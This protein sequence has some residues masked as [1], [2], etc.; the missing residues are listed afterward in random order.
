MHAYAPVP[1]CAPTRQSLLSGEWPQAHGGL[2]NYGVGLPL[3]LFDRPTWSEALAG[4]GYRL[5]YVGKWGVHPNR[6]PLAFGFH[7]WVSS[8]DYAAW[9]SA[10]SLPAPVSSAESIKELRDSPA[11]RWF[12]GS[13]PV[14]AGCSRTHWCADATIDL[15]ERYTHTGRTNDEARPWC[16]QLALEEP[17]L[18]PYPAGEFAEMYPPETIPP[19]GS[20]GD[21]LNG[22][23]YIQRQQR[24][25]WGIEELGWGAWS[26]FVVYED[27]DNL[28]L[29]RIYYYQG[30]EA[31]P[32]MDRR[33]R[34]RGFLAPADPTVT[35]TYLV[36]EGDAPIQGDSLR[37]NGVDVQ[38]GCNPNRNVF[39][40][41]I[42]SGRADGS[43]LEGVDGVDLDTFTVEGAIDAGD[44]E[45]EI[46][47]VVPRG[48]GLVTP[49][50]VI[51]TDWLVLAFDHR[52]PSF[53]SVKPQ[54]EAQ[55][56]TGSSVEP[57]QRIDYV[58][59]IENTGGDLANDV[60]VQDGIPEHTTYI[61]GSARV[62][63]QAVAD[64]GD[65]SPFEDGFDVSGFGGIG[66]FEPGERHVVAFSVQVDEG[67]PRGAE[68]RNV[69][70][71]R[72]REL[73]ADEE[74]DPV[75]HLVG[76]ATDMRPPPPPRDMDPPD[77]DMA[78]AGVDVGA[79]PDAT[80]G[81][82]LDAGRCPPG[83]RVDIRGDCED[84]P[85]PDAGPM[86]MDDPVCGPGAQR[87][88]GQ[89]ALI[90]GEGL[91]WDTN[92]D[93]C[94]RC[95]IATDMPCPER[96]APGDAEDKGGSD[97]GCGCDGT[98]VGGIWLLM[99]PGLRRRRR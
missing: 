90:C 67:A 52:L 82:D 76:D 31:L 89:C 57:G 77:P 20:L 12:G 22:K 10:R 29:R 99:L 14:P 5:G 98:G 73:E 37:V 59:I 66:A 64:I 50:E 23:P 51:F 53:E 16:I 71:I 80:G 18:P 17:H 62:G 43:C 49:G 88:D 28:P 84:A 6:S 9:R 40:G 81:G 39:N 92:C 32:G 83:Q 95:R 33:V 96:G 61:A 24:V 8:R 1:C 86:C 38:D 85:D 54:K 46:H 11:A 25:S 2:W 7:D 19:W 91:V 75:V 93:A 41:T 56:P 34:A 27:E 36:Y 21:A 94:G 4:V 69:A 15:I 63:N 70:R 47:Y 97:A 87:V 35:L 65:G 45:A 60:E 74:T 55:P 79:D 13:D 26:L 30:F 42:N 58:I 68:I 72:A 48:D 44:E 3:Q 78:G